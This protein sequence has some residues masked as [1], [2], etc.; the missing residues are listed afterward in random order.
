MSDSDSNAWFADIASDGSSVAEQLKSIKT[1]A[2]EAFD[3]LDKDQN[4]YISRKELELAIAAD[5]QYTEQKFL[6]FLLENHE[7]IAEACDE[8][9]ASM[10]GI[11]RDDLEQYF[12]L[13]A[14]LL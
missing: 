10:E 7:Q 4:G 11:S 5:L 12:D 8:G 9:G 1:F 3:K 6:K 13:I 14:T 2:Y